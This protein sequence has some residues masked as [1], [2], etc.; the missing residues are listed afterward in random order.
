MA[1]C[2]GCRWNNDLAKKD[3]LD[4]VHEHG[5]GYAKS[6]LRENIRH[7]TAK[8]NGWE[9]PSWTVV[10]DNNNH[11]TIGDQ[12][13]IDITEG[14]ING[15][16]KDL[17]SQELK[18][19]VPIEVETVRQAE[20]LA[21]LGVKVIYLPEHSPMGV[22]FMTIYRQ[23]SENP[24]KYIGT[25]KDLGEN[26]S[27][28]QAKIRMQSML[29]D[30]TLSFAQSDQ[31]KDAFVFGLK[32][33]SDANIHW[34]RS[35]EPEKNRVIKKEDL[36]EH[37][38]QETH[39]P[40]EDPLLL[41]KYKEEFLSLQ[42]HIQ[43][44]HAEMQQTVKKL[45]FI[46]E[47]KVAI[48]ATPI[49]LASLSKEL[50]KPIRAVEKSIA[51]HKRKERR[52]FVVAERKKAKKL[53]A[54]KR[55]GAENRTLYVKRRKEAIVVHFSLKQEIKKA[56]FSLKKESL[57]SPQS[58]K[59]WTK[60][61][62]LLRRKEK[63][64]K[65]QRKLLER[66]LVRIVRKINKLEKRPKVIYKPVLVKQ[67]EHRFHLVKPRLTDMA[68]KEIRRLERK[69]RREK[70]KEAILKFS[71]A[72]T[73]WV[74]MLSFPRTRESI[75]DIQHSNHGS[76]IRPASP[77]RGESGMTNNEN[78]FPSQEPAPWILLSIIWYLTMIREGG[79]STMPINKYTNTTNN[80]MKTTIQP[81]GVIFAYA[82]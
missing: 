50:P 8:R 75:N 26:V 69:L 33:A 49:L 28:D 23:D 66:A 18:D 30:Q 47:T 10:L 48:G 53:R 4:Q 36:T 62:L 3:F 72:W 81:Q 9:I 14:P 52:R 22:R 27:F 82:S 41:S 59:K 12:T 51:R 39:Q 80:Q 1:G 35:F 32:H 74:L 56:G 65:K 37:R 58:E 54:I 15:K 61:V 46:A 71:F 73:L 76:P 63:K 19:I 6:Y 24:R 64:Q 43:Q 45:K 55:G 20:R 40:K 29:H 5:T 25:Q 17:A 38:I 42:E 11:L 57:A 16:N 13:L 34:P 67:A 44:K 31:Q 68:P 2:E 70:K 78:I 79:V 7:W 21:S 60:E 77:N